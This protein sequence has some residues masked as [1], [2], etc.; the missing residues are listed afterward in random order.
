MGAELLEVLITPEQLQARITELAARIDA[1][2]AGRE[3]I[4]IGVLKGA[5]MVMADLARAMHLPVSMDWMAI[6]SYGSGT[7]AAGGVR[8][9][10]ELDADIGGR[11]VVGVEDGVGAGLTLSYLGH[12]LQARHP[13]SGHGC[14]MQP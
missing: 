13:A 9:L 7:T 3:L 5:V 10:K 12:N 8:I 6:S 11:H 1:D 4:L 2:Y 14:V